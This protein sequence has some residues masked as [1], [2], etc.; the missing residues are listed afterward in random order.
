MN[1]QSPRGSHP[2]GVPA[3]PR[4]N[5]RRAKWLAL[6]TIP[7]LLLAMTSSVAVGAEMTSEYSY[8]GASDNDRKDPVGLVFIGPKA[9]AQSVRVSLSGVMGWGSGETSTNQ[10]F[11]DLTTNSW[12]KMQAENAS[13]CGG[14]NRTHVRLGTTSG[15]KNVNGRL[16][17]YTVGTPHDDVVRIDCPGHVARRFNGARDKV[18]S[19]YAARG[20]R[21]TQVWWD[22]RA[23]MKQC[24]GSYEGSDDGWVKYV[25]TL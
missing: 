18:A 15:K 22:N 25:W 12:R 20:R 1:R 4:A 5:R 8:G 24:D 2:P 3:N 7:A 19:A 23:K 14:C 13:G 16:L 21:V 11:K 6:S 9:D 10:W 17:D